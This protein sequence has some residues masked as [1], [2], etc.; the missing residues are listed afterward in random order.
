MDSQKLQI[1]SWISVD[2]KYDLR[3]VTTNWVPFP[4]II[5]LPVYTQHLT[6]AQKPNMQ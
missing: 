4:N 3:A 2:K 5:L 6:T 1:K